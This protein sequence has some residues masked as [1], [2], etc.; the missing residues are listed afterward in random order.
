[1]SP[2]GRIPF[3]RETRWGGLVLG[4]SG[5]SVFWGLKGFRVDGFRLR[6]L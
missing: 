2:H 4:S 5:V 3:H 6:G 1:M